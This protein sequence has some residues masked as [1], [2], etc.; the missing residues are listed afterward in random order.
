MPIINFDQ[1]SNAMS[2]THTYC[3]RCPS[4]NG[5]QYA[6][7]IQYMSKYHIYMY[8]NK[9]TI[10]MLF[11]HSNNTKLAH[12]ANKQSENSKTITQTQLGPS[13]GSPH[14]HS[15]LSVTVQNFQLLSQSWGLKYTAISASN[16]PTI[17]KV[18]K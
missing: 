6:N 11:I 9:H 16:T 10:R 18:L 1:S 8:S 17:N 3:L 5:M 4:A 14:T 12:R 13:K 15:K 2:C 7:F